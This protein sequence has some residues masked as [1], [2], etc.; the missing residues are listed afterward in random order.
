MEQPKPKITC[1]HNGPYVLPTDFPTKVVVD[2]LNSKGESCSTPGEVALCRCG[3]SDNK[4]FCDGTHEKIGFIDDKEADRE[5]DIRTDYVGKRVTIHDNRGICAHSGH[6]TDNLPSVFDVSNAPWI[7]P[8]G[9]S[10]QEIIDTVKKCPSGALSHTVDGV[11]HR[12]QE[13]EPLLT[14]TRD[15]PYEITGGIELMEQPRGE[16]ASIEHYSLCRCGAS[17][18]KP[19]CDGAHLDIDF[20]DEKN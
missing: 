5:P 12:D 16:E 9:A 6:C 1:T 18:N 20:K 13:R 3:G 17:K 8:F 19:F 11:E 4:P 15:G 10:D 2:I 7:D 14:V